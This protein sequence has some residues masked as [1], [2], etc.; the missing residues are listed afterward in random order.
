M[1]CKLLFKTVIGYVARGRFTLTFNTG[2]YFFSWRIAST[3]LSRFRT[4]LSFFFQSGTLVW[5]TWKIYCKQFQRRCNRRRISLPKCIR[6]EFRLLCVENFLQFFFWIPIYLTITLGLLWPPFD[7]FF[8]MVIMNCFSENLALIIHWTV[9]ITEFT[10]MQVIITT[11]CNASSP[12]ESTWKPSICG[13][14][15]RKVGSVLITHTK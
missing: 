2:T 4:L 3:G 14:Q 1:S 13:L 15:S 6:M 12:Q 9:K 8:P 11:T 5:Q 7:K 10:E